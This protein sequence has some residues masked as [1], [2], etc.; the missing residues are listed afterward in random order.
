MADSL[1]GPPAPTPGQMM[2]AGILGNSRIPPEAVD[3]MSQLLALTEA[4][5]TQQ[6]SVMEDYFKNYGGQL[7]QS[8]QE[9]QSA[10]TQTV[11]KP[12]P[13]N[14]GLMALNKAVGSFAQTLSP[15]GD[16]IQRAD[17]RREFEIGQMKE[18]RLEQLKMQEQDA[19]Q[20]SQRAQ[21]FGDEQAKLTAV[22]KAQKLNTVRQ[23]LMGGMESYF[24]MKDESNQKWID[25]IF[26]LQKLTAEYSLKI[27]TGMVKDPKLEAQ[28]NAEKD[29]FDKKAEIAIQTIKGL[30]NSL[31]SPDEQ[32]KVRLQTTKDL[33]ELTA[34][35]MQNVNNLVGQQP[36]P[37]A[38]KQFGPAVPM[39]LSARAIV[40][41]A[42]DNN[43]IDPK[44]IIAHTKV[45][46]ESGNFEGL[47]V[48]PGT[49]PDS[50]MEAVRKEATAKAGTIKKKV[51][52]LHQLQLILKADDTFGVKAFINRPKLEAEY[53]Q[54]VKEVGPYARKAKPIPPPS[55]PPPSSVVSAP[56]LDSLDSAGIRRMMALRSGDTL[57]SYRTI[58]W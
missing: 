6:D 20:A 7:R 18:R 47:G 28:L 13:I 38:G 21:E 53:N 43:V 25:H 50:L 52:R 57:S 10:F 39:E 45:A 30:D 24:K 31:L 33:E 9:K 44:A 48:A 55:T 1:Y 36:P 15:K 27:K 19:M 2:L 37:Q 41:N 23:A 12:L 5:Q 22:N 11:Q 14:A 26:D 4:G 29:A 51:D 56:P 42:I 3:R 54:L 17:Q 8:A 32:A 58:A 34:Q 49:A 35:H 16:F 46:I 40:Q